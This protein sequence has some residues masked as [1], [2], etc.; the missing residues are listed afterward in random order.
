MPD[1]TTAHPDD[2]IDTQASTD[3]ALAE[4][5][6]D[7][8]DRML[9]GDEEARPLDVDDETGDEALDAL[10]RG[11][12]PTEAA[13]SVAAELDDEAS[14]A[15]VVEDDG[16]DDDEGAPLLPSELGFGTP[17]CLAA[18]D[19]LEDRPADG[20]IE[21]IEVKQ[22]VWQAPLKWLARPLD[23]AGDSTRDAVGKV[24]VVTM[25]NAVAV[26]LFVALT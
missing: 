3:E 22:P 11:E 23:K 6:D 13:T 4:L 15:A 2:P 7:A 19:A 1:T 10:L 9:R 16:D 21:H 20:A 25:L 12:D 14:P 26:L 17:D 5:A 18:D 24:A 8:I